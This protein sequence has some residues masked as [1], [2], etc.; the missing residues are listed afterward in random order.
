M[1]FT[2]IILDGLAGEITPEQ[3]QFEQIVLQNARQLQSMIVDLL[4]VTRM[5]NGKLSVERR[6]YP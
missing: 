2:G 6:F 4:E 1:Q 5:E 3:R